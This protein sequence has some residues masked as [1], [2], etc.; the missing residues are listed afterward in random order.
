MSFDVNNKTGI[1]E[2]LPVTDFLQFLP[3]IGAGIGLAI[4]SPLSGLLSKATKQFINYKTVTTA[5]TLPTKGI[6]TLFSGVKNPTI[7]ANKALI[8]GGLTVGGLGILSLSPGG[9]NLVDTSGQSIH[10]IAQ[11]GNNITD[12]ISKNPIVPIALIGLGFL[13]VIG[14]MKK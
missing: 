13:V 4:T 11:V 3:S 2:P 1:A 7:T 6:S 14:A 10:D 5:P 8:G 12:F 9:Q